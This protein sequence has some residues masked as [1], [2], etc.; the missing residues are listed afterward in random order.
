MKLGKKIIIFFSTCLVVSC[1]AVGILGYWSAVKGFDKALSEKVEGDVKYAWDIMNKNT[2]G[3]WRE[4]NG[5]LYKGVTP[6]ED[7]REINSVIDTLGKMSNNEATIFCGDTVVATTIKNEQGG[8]DIGGKASPEV[9]ERVL[10]EGKDLSG[11][12]EILGEPYYVCYKPIFDDEDKVVG[13]F[14]LGTHASILSDMGMDFL[15]S[16]GSASVLIALAMAMLVSWMT[17]KQI[18]RLHNV[19]E[20]LNQIANGNIAIHDIAVQGKDEL[21]E[22]SSDTNKMKNAIKGLMG[23]IAYSSEQVAAASEELTATATQT[24]ESVKV[25]ADS[26][27]QMAAN[28]QHQVDK[29]HSVQAKAE[30]MKREMAAVSSCSNVMKRSADTSIEDAQNGITKVTQ[31]TDSIQQISEKVQESSE[32]VQELNRRTASVSEVVDTISEIARQ[33][34]LLALN[35]AIEAAR[36]GEQGKGFAVV[37]EEIRALAEQCHEA[38][39]RIA[40]TI[41]D[42]VEDTE[43]VVA[44]MDENIG[45][46]RTGVEI[47]SESGEAFTK[48]FSSVG[49]MHK[50]IENTMGLI[51]KA[52]DE[53]TDIQVSINAVVDLGKQSFEEAQNI[54]ASTEEQAAMINEISNAAGSMADQ[55]Q[56]LQLE[57]SKFKV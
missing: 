30:S 34:N 17:R 7:N 52:D 14:F 21:A 42:I 54:S 19:Q 55:A 13:I 36:A 56:E 12:I 28:N 8:R 6:I 27:V 51:K 16:T 15:M 48:I 44:S 43:K 2:T 39:K 35:A 5:K 45:Y 9:V 37:S 49:D 25:V 41:A 3:T 18:A 10:T 26:A 20:A 50:Q 46:V 4:K 23:K 47:V 31:A 57:I 24:T 22:L 1:L 29:L 53:C 38:T 40:A 32:I 33:T 11:K